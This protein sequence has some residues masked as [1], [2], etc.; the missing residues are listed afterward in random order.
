[1]SEEVTFQL[2][3]NAYETQFENNYRNCREMSTVLYF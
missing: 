3:A 1:L 2:P